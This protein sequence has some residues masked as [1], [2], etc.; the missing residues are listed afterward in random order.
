[1]PP[2]KPRSNGWLADACT[3]LACPRCCI[4]VTIRRFPPIV[5]RI[6]VRVDTL[7]TVCSHAMLLINERY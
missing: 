7:D 3:L 1:M 2:S 6:D 4:A 5:V